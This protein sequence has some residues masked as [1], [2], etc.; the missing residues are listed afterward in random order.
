MLNHASANAGNGSFQRVYRSGR[1]FQLKVFHVLQS[2]SFPTLTLPAAPV[3][4]QHMR[5]NVMSNAGVEDATCTRIG[6]VTA[7]VRAHHLP[8]FITKRASQ[9]L[10]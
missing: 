4:E 3:T 5:L 7:K 9:V 2:L 6:V 8:L 1:A 10:K